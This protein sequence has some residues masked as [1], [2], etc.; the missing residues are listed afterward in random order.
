MDKLKDIIQHNFLDVHIVSQIVEHLP[1]K[2]TELALY[3]LNYN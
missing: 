3:E 1:S 2:Q